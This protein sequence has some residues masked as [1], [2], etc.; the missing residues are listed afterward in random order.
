MDNGCIL[1]LAGSTLHNGV[2]DKRSGDNASKRRRRS[3]ACARVR[4]ETIRFV[5]SPPL[6]WTPQLADP[7]VAEP[8]PKWE[9]GAIVE[10]PDVACSPQVIGDVPPQAI[11]ESAETKSEKTYDTKSA[12]VS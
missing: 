11:A 2:A 1:D 8:V 7:W 12:H 4:L 5:P 3:R 6:C 10:F 9:D